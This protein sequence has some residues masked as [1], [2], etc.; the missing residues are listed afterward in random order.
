MG[1]LMKLLIGLTVVVLIIG[2]V[3][4]IFLAYDTISDIVERKRKREETNAGAQF[5]SRYCDTHN[6]PL[7]TERKA[8]TMVEKGY[9]MRKV[10]RPAF[11]DRFRSKAHDSSWHIR[12]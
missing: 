9:P 1:M 10:P 12:R 7:D 11:R 2:I 6:V 4:I 5:V 3:T 8:R